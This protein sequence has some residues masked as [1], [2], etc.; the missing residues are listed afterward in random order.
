[1]KQEDEIID[2][3]GKTSLIVRERSS[4]LLMPVMDL[5]T[6]K[7]RLREF[8]EFCAHYLT[9]S[10]DGGNDGGDYGVIPG[11]KKKTLLKSGSDK[12]AELYGLYDEYVI[13][14]SVENWEKGLFDYTLKCVLKSRRD[15]SMVGAGVGSCSSFESKYRWRDM[16]RSCPQCG[17]QTIIKG[18]EKFGGGWICWRKEGK[19]DGC[20]AKFGDSD[21]SITE[22][23]VGRV[24]NPDIIDSKNT[25]LKMAKKRAK[26]DA[27]I[28]VTRSSGIFT[29]DMDDIPMPPAK[30]PVERT[31]EE[32]PLKPKETGAATSSA[33]PGAQASGGV[34]ESNG[35]PSSADDVVYIDKNA[36]I[37][38]ARFVK[39]LFPKST[40]EKEIERMR[41]EWLFE[42]HFVEAN[43]NATSAMI[44]LSQFSAVK[45]AIKEDFIRLLAEKAL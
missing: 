3:E 44:P 38:F 18:Q 41:H 13:I 36:Q 27:V 39:E 31:T 12:L 9:E 21:K 16:K 24:E 11:T 8:E 4:V 1:M 10:E 33:S 25:V 5:N 19:S 28:G 7:N 14:S 34:R 20:G 43:G 42:H 17:K 40:P 15:D 30:P 23:T 37:G 2:V 6:A 35:P 26:I 45:K 32:I 29:Q 22:Q